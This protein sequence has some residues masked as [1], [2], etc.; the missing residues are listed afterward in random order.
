MVDAPSKEAAG[1]L[2]FVRKTQT[3]VEN[4]INYP[5]FSLSGLA[6]IDMPRMRTTQAQRLEMFFT[7]GYLCGYFECCNHCVR[8]PMI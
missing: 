8:P 7:E 4:K 2:F 6:E 5:E 3:G 1:G